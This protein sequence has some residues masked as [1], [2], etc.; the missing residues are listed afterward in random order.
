MEAESRISRGFLQARLRQLLAELPSAATPLKVIPVAFPVVKIGFQV[1]E[2][3]A[4]TIGLVERYVMEAL[5]D[6]GPMSAA[7]LGTM[8]GLEPRV[9]SRAADRMIESGGSV[10]RESGKY[11]VERAG[12]DKAQIK[13]ITTTRSF[14]F[15]GV[16]G[17]LVPIGL[18]DENQAW[19]L[20]PVRG[21]NRLRDPQGC[22]PAIRGWFN[23][24]H[25]LIEV[26]EEIER[27]I[28]NGDSRTKEHLGIP[29]GLSAV[30]RRD[31]H[32]D[33][34]A[35]IPAL[36]A[37]FTEGAYQVRGF[38]QDASILLL[39]QAEAG[40]RWIERACNGLAPRDFTPSYAMEDMS[41][42]ID[43]IAP[44]AFLR[45]GPGAGEFMLGMRETM[46]WHLKDLFGAEEKSRDAWLSAV[47]TSGCWWDLSDYKPSY[48]LVTITPADSATTRL[49]WLLRG[50]QE[51]LRLDEQ[52][53]RP[54]F[55]L[56]TWWA[57]LQ[58]KPLFVQRIETT[59]LSLDELREVVDFTPDM[60]LQEKFELLW[61]ESRLRAWVPVS[62]PK[63]APKFSK[64]PA[65][66]LNRSPLDCIE[67]EF[68]RLA[69]ASTSE[70]RVISPLVDNPAVIDS[71]I[72]ARRR[73][74]SVQVI[75]ELLERQ[76]DSVSFPNQGFGFGEKENTLSD[77]FD[78]TRRLA[79]NN[80]R[81]RCPRF[82]PHAKLWLFDGVKAVVTSANLTNNSLGRG[83]NPAI[84]AGIVFE[85]EAVVTELARV[86]EHLWQTCPYK[87]QLSYG[88]ISLSEEAQEKGPQ[89]E[90]RIIRNAHL[91]THWNIPPSSDDLL[92]KI[93]AE[94][95]SAKSTL[96]ISALSLYD[97]KDV[98]SLH[99][100]LVKAL[101]RG[102]KVT[103]VVRH[104]H[105]PQQQY[106]D[107][108]TNEL[109]RCGLRLV[110]RSHLHLKAMLVDECQVGLFSAN[111]NPYSLNTACRSAHIE[112][113]VFGSANGVLA[114]AAEFLK[115]TAE[116]PEYEYRPHAV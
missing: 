6:F 83:K 99:S 61:K 40:I 84:E 113:G 21:N 80:V 77:H 25:G 10:S 74:L 109:L 49:F 107:P 52:K 13:E 111:F 36:I 66:L 22:E 16:T 110:T 1:R 71:L 69:D 93:I 116:S 42:Q 97:T 101:E 47:L 100:A 17:R 31:P 4:W 85:D 112:L 30:G 58:R 5:R 56:H 8:L 102:I 94:I 37:V 68:A 54:D 9:I 20:S 27:L 106:P 96:L 108:S 62:P 41:A 114:G 43:Q 76:K 45:K 18:L 35:W 70:I 2:R 95:D 65:L 26:R 19:R 24:N 48:A 98:P 75:T 86:F 55:D 12:E 7:E 79:L 39:E 46:T 82:C 51:L 15:S 44:G 104:D 73:N 59:P 32:A 11:A 90:D 60:A 105:F 92:K 29:V 34:V 57:E 103:V 88:N 50:R 72:R 63:K 28:R 23:S 87:Q 81:C 53:L 115:H 64:P 78:A 33:E 38:M 14:L 89:A 67:V 3:A 91:Q